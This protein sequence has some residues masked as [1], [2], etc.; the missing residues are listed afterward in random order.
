[1][2]VVGKVMMG[3]MNSFSGDWENDKST[4]EVVAGYRDNS[5][6]ANDKKLVW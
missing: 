3:R 5:F 2:Q 4:A 1:M 6:S